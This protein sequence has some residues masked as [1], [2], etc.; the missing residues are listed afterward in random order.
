M[1]YEVINKLKNDKKFLKYLRENSYWYKELNRNANNYYKFIKVMK[2]KYKLRTI[3]KVDN[4]VDSVDLIAK[5][6]NMSNE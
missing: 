2:E 6:V 1:K 5:I 3:D 4:F